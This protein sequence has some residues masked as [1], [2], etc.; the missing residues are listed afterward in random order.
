[1]TNSQSQGPKRGFHFVRLRWKT[2]S[3]PAIVAAV[4]T[5]S[6]G[7]SHGESTGKP[8]A[9]TK[10]APATQEQIEGTIHVCSSCHGFGGRS[11]S[12]TFPRLAGQRSEYIETQLKA[13]RDHARADPHAHTYMWGMAAH[14]SD[15]LIHGIALYY[16]AQIPV[17]GTRG[18]PAEMAAGKKIFQEGI[19][20]RGVPPCQG[21]HG[22]HAE[23]M[24]PIPRLAGQHRDY[25]IEQLQNFASNA[26]ANEIMHEN[27]K[28]LTADDIRQV[29][30][31]IAAQ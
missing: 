10:A 5:V 18:D 2:A 9:D 1:M 12:P 15:P 29:T 17:S 13:F 22:E 6:A 16:A 25:L 27:S 21:C 28:P 23:G 7:M 30:V 26:R 3:V 14:L 11:V 20:N 31:Y 24:G 19:S 8:A 4:L